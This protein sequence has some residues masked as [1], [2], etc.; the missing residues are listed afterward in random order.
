LFKSN[1]DL[2]QENYANAQ[3][4]QSAVFSLDASCQSF[5]SQTS[6]S[7]CTTV[8]S[9]IDDEDEDVSNGDAMANSWCSFGDE[10]T[11][12]SVP[13]RHKKIVT[14][15]SQKNEFQEYL[16]KIGYSVTYDNNDLFVKNLSS[17]IKGGNDADIEQKLTSHHQPNILY[18]SATNIINNHNNNNEPKKLLIKDEDLLAIKTKNE[19]HQH[20]TLVQ[21]V[22]TPG[23]SHEAQKYARQAPNEN[24]RYDLFDLA[25]KSL[26]NNIKIVAAECQI[27]SEKSKKP[28]D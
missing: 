6:S 7:V 11:V 5:V 24:R 9:N 23:L 3:L 18:Q 10:S 19:P 22:Y 26:I 13:V 16:A 12:E 4:E 28:R 25:N 1:W 15:A 17:K 20:I 8:I 14:R 27:S 2:L 21:N